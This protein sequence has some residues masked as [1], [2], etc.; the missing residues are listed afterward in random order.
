MASWT[1]NNHPKQFTMEQFNCS[2]PVSEII[3]DINSFARKYENGKVEQYKTATTK[4]M[5]C[6][7]VQTNQVQS[8]PCK[9]L[10]NDFT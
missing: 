1:V 4:C 8:K 2:H 10:F 5:F 3:G 9:I 7:I 6:N